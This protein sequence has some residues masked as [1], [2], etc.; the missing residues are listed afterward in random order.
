MYA[1]RIG[2]KILQIFWQP[3]V[4]EKQNGDIIGYRL[5][6]REKRF[7]SP[8]RKYVTLP[9]TQTMHTVDDLKPYTVYDI[10][11]EAKTAIGYGPAQ[12]LDYLTGEAGNST[13]HPI[14][15]S[16]TREY[17]CHMQ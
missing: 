9:E 14:Y 8:C 6:I 11:V 17:G 5:C 4:A 12:Y 13:Q 1:N 15:Q 7:T 16:T 3:P 2:P 10:H